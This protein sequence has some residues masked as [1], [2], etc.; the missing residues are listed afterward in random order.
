M[1]NSKNL[2]SEISAILLDR[3]MIL[4]G[5]YGT[6]IQQYE[7][8]EDSFRGELLKN[9]HKSLLGNNDLLTI[10]RPDIVSEIHKNY[11]EAGCDI[12]STNTFSSTSIAQAD[13]DTQELCKDLNKIGASLA[14]QIANQYSTPEKPRFV[15]GSIGPTNRTASLSPDVNRPGYRNIYFD[16]LFESY[17]EAMKSLVDGGVDLFLIETIFDTLNAKAAIAA[18][19]ELN[20]SLTSPK[21]IIISGTITDAS[22][23]T[24]SGQ[25]VQAFLASVTHSNALAIGF[26]CALGAEQLRPYTQ[27]LSTHCEAPIS[28]F[29]NAGLPNAFGEYEQ[30]PE[31]MASIVEEFATSGWI[32]IVGG[33]CGTTP[34]HIRAISKVIENKLPRQPALKADSLKLSGLELLNINEESLLVNV[35]ERTNVT[36]SAKFAR[37]I[38]EENYDETISVA[39]Q[40]IENGAQVIDVNMDEGMLDGKKAMSTFLNLIAS[41]PD[42]SRVPIMVDSSQWE[43]IEEGLKCIQGKAIVNSI[44]LKE[45]EESFLSHAKKCQTY[46]AA[47]VVMAFDEE[48]QADTFERKIEICRRSYHLL[49]DK[50]DFNPNDIIFDPNIFA[51]GTG[52][53]EHQNYAVDFIRAVS[54]IKKNLPGARTSGGLSN[55]SF[56][57]RGNNPLREAIHTVFLFHAVK[58]G[59]TMAIVNAGQ[60]GVYDEIPVELREL[61]ED[62]VLNRRADATER[63]LD[64]ADQFTDEGKSLEADKLPDWRQLTVEERLSHALVKGITEHI[65]EDTEEARLKASHPL[66]VIEGPLMNGMNV[67]GDL[68]GSGKMFLPQVVKSARV[69]KSAVGHLI[70]FIEK[71][72]SRSNSSNGK[73]IMATVKGDVHDIGKNIVGVVLQCN[74]YEVI[75]LG[76]MV[77]AEKILETAQKEQADLIGLSGLI[78]PSLNEMVHVAEE[79]QRLNM[80]TPLLIGG[81]TTSKAHTATKIEPAYHNSATIYVTDASRAVNVAASLL[82]GQ[83]TYQKYTT[84]ILEEYETV[85]NRVEARRSKQKFLKLAD[86]RANGHPIN[87][88]AYKPPI[89]ASLGV[90]EYSLSV[91][92]LV[93]F[94]DWSPFFMTWELAGKYPNILDDETVGEAARDLFKDAQTLLNKI[95]DEKLLKPRGVY[96]FWACNRKGF[97][98]VNVYSDN[99]RTKKIMTLHHLRQQTPKSNDAEPNYCLAD[100][101]AP[102]GHEDYIG[103]F[104]VTSGNEVQDLLND[105]EDDYSKIMIQALADRLAEAFAEAMHQHVRTKAWGYANEEQLGHEE[106]IKEKYIGIRPAPGYP[107]CPEHSEK[108]SLFELLGVTEKIGITLT[109]NYAMSPAASVSGWMFSHPDAKYFGVGK[110]NEEQVLDYSIRKNIDFPNAKKL[111]LPNLVS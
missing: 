96:G 14:K 106:L 18:A 50:V 36:G 31:E 45:G 35:G 51:I 37:L 82:G 63:L 39:R 102:P 26:N 16:Q 58:A 13:F 70:P 59:L 103:G 62:L 23:R 79:M 100:F 52:I 12:L 42:I 108:E 21:P 95:S 68:F 56:S 93:P 48:G 92:D 10:T 105:Y 67:V 30:S 69:M 75:D 81:A 89:P 83:E 64:G 61:V 66:E 44:S 53:E 7:L 43:I 15:A 85:R 55:V 71:D 38:R 72:K 28:V 3:I 101:T 47:A 78:T 84:S 29:P 27:E 99:F 32:N 107:A 4:D 90:N 9:H 25:T 57:F 6:A 80:K 60:L 24:L 77:P 19:H 41:E 109:E 73:I 49:V 74:N 110:L 1:L 11:L 17:L 104:A 88:E 46:G 2:K 22:G 86:A 65:I 87:W 8:Q 33:C 98:D 40:Q 97:D 94:I 5:A 76:V 54:W 20:S 111:L 34:D 91:R